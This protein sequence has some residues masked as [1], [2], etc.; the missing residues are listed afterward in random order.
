MAGS[1]H[2]Q[3]L[4]RESIRGHQW[5]ART[6][7]KSKPRSSRFRSIR[8]F[9]HVC[10]RL[11]VTSS[12]T[13]RTCHQHTQHSVLSGADRGS[14]QQKPSVLLPGPGVSAGRSTH[15]A[16]TQYAISMH[17][18]C[19]QHALGMHSACTRHALGMQSE[20]NWHAIR[21][22]LAC[23]PSRH[24]PGAARANAQ[25]CSALAARVPRYQS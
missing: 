18:V 4:T 3:V 19:H 24:A 17:S 2:V 16:C 14:F 10:G 11:R 8:T 25:R 7:Y 9:A 23:N 1:D 21:M 6:M 12:C 5:Q 22:Q 15:S 13:T 20:C